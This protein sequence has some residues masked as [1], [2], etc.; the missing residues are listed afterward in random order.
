MVVQIDDFDAGITI[1]M[2][3]RDTVNFITS[4]SIN[5]IRTVNNAIGKINEYGER[6]VISCDEEEMYLIENYNT[7]KPE[8]MYNFMLKTNA[9]I[10]LS[11]V[12]EVVLRENK[13]DV[14]IFIARYNIKTG[15]APYDLVA[16]ALERVHQFYMVYG[17]ESYKEDKRYHYDI[18]NEEF[19]KM[20]NKGEIK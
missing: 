9:N 19:L 11:F 8:S 7:F 1:D 6:I 5:I 20:V 12:E 13:K 16:K 4:L 14:N 15:M 18:Y 2:G 10:L 3:A 17:D